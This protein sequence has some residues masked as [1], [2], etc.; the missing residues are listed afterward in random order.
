MVWTSFEHDVMFVFSIEYTT[1]DVNG[2]TILNLA[3]IENKTEYV[4][5]LV[6]KEE[7]CRGASKWYYMY[8]MMKNIIIPHCVFFLN[9]H[10]IV[11][12][13]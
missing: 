10:C 12:P 6:K 13:Q 7:G 4:R 8:S 9:I 5:F 11:F 3:I 1:N 2:Y